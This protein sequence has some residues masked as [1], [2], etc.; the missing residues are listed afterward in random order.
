MAREF[1]L[2]EKMWLDFFISTFLKKLNEIPKNIGNKVLINNDNYM[3]K[4]GITTITE[5]TELSNR[6][7][8]SLIREIVDYMRDEQC[9]CVID[10]TLVNRK[11]N[12]NLNDSGLKSRVN[13]WSTAVN[14][15]N[16][17]AS[18]K[19]RCSTLLYTVE[20]IEQ[21]NYLYKTRL[22]IFLRSKDPEHLKYCEGKLYEKLG[23]LGIS[24]SVGAA[25][26][27]D[28]LEHTSIICAKKESVK[29]VGTCLV[30]T[31]KI[32][33]QLLPNVHGRGDSE[34]ICMGIDSVNNEVFKADINSN[35]NARNIAVYGVSGVGKTVIVAFIC[36]SAYEQGNAVIASDIKGN[37][38]SAF[39]KYTDGESVSL[40]ST[41]EECL[42]MFV[43]KPEEVDG[44]N[45]S[46]YFTRR[47]EFLLKEYV[48]LAEEKDAGNVSE[49]RVLLHNFFTMLYIS[50]GVVSSNIKTWYKTDNLDHF[51]VFKELKQY[52]RNSTEGSK[53]FVRSALSKWAIFFEYNAPRS[54]AFRK[55]FDL[56][57]L[58]SKRALVFDFGLLDKDESDR[59]VIID[60][61]YMYMS[62]I[63]SRFIKKKVSEGI[64][65]YTILEES[66]F[67][68]E[69][70][71]REYYAK[72]WTLKRS[73][74]IVNI[75]LGNSVDKIN[76]SSVGSSIL[77]NT[78]ALL[79]GPLKSEPR[80]FLTRY[81]ELEK[82]KGV[83]DN[84][85]K[86]NKYKHS[87]LFIDKMGKYN[88]I[89]PILSVDRKNRS[90]GKLEY[91]LTEK[92]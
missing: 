15:A 36:A 84:I 27:R 22:F 42:N 74:G 44:T 47:V 61:K 13:M 8:T 2:R 3:S 58:V 83:L 91:R 12:V 7:P 79:I 55:E 78:T 65:I 48:I 5:I 59:D 19:L 6:T 52:V 11:Y 69:D 62:E 76:Q 75:M 88:K 50:I 92:S 72:Y 82:F 77:E 21:G 89:K 70:I 45:P 4:L 35:T 20:Q 57:N 68:S 1:F 30:T 34:G 49:L 14:S 86:Y 63:Q 16:A 40:R 71:M 18:E 81:F 73:Q 28:T 32:L 64:N 60:L 67:V 87:F 37:E 51:K 66:N 17:L 80:D 54:Y 90:D 29:N 56:D 53:E 25:N 38:F 85:N 39:S 31:P 10:Y 24:Y 41:S 23:V 26:V 43:M 46:E 33:S 9:E